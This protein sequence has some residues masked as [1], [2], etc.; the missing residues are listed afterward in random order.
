MA[1]TTSI[2]VDGVYY[3]CE[4]ADAREQI[5][6]LESTK[7]DKTAITVSGTGLVITTT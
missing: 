5:E 6:T 3:P 1:N 2:T 7:L 4:D